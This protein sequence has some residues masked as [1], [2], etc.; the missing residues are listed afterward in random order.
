MEK[1]VKSYLSQ[2]IWFTT[3]S[4][5]CFVGL[6]ALGFPL[7]NDLIIDIQLPIS[8]MVGLA[9]LIGMI[10]LFIDQPDY[11]RLEK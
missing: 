2:I 7:F 10:M 9:G 1:V 6:S 3:A 5:S 11:C 4:V 8:L